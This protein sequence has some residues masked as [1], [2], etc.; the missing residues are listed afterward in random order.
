MDIIVDTQ[1]Y[2]IHIH[3]ID[4]FPKREERSEY[5]TCN[6]EESSEQQ[7]NPSDRTSSIKGMFEQFNRDMAVGACIDSALFGLFSMGTHTN[8]NEP[9]LESIVPSISLFIHSYLYSYTTYYIHT[10]EIV[11]TTTTTVQLAYIYIFTTH[12]ISK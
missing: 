12:R 8:S 9:I 6:I 7:G 2:M 3:I 10:I 5:C 4:D 1:T 11:S